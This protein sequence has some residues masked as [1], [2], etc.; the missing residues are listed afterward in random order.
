MINREIPAAHTRRR[1]PRRV[2]SPRETGRPVSSGGTHSRPRTQPQGGATLTSTIDIACGCCKGRHATKEQVR[3]CCAGR[4][5][6]PNGYRRVGVREPRLAPVEPDVEGIDSDS[7]SRENEPRPDRATGFLGAT[8]P[9]PVDRPPN[10]PARD[11]VSFVDPDDL[12]TVDFVG[13]VHAA[14][15]SMRSQRH[16]VILES[17]LGADGRPALTL[18]AVANEFGV[19]RERIRQLEAKAISRLVP[20]VRNVLG[21]AGSF[22]PLVGVLR[23]ANRADTATYAERVAAVSALLCPEWSPVI[24]R[25]LVMAVAGRTDKSALTLAIPNS[26][27]REAQ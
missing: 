14:L 18:E 5:R 8:A 20:G 9:T 13:A 17:R 2:S 4:R 19:T 21:T 10:A 22:D 16:A 11:I 24:A 25:R 1:I 3:A 26:T 7:Q 6:E 12:R 23:P 15:R 27:E